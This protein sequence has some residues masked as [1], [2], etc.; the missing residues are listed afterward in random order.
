MP[1]WLSVVRVVSWYLQLAMVAT[2]TK[3]G[4]H[5]D[6]RSGYNDDNIYA[7]V[8]D[9]TYYPA[10]NTLATSLPNTNS[11]TSTTREGGG[12]GTPSNGGFFPNQPQVRF[13]RSRISN[14]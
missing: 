12:I 10:N 4:S 13:S 14:S 5:Y 11:T 7:K 3:N 6:F 9:M 2:L 8:D 1:N